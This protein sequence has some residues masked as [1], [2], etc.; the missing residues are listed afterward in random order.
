M[1]NRISIDLE[2][3]NVNNRRRGASAT[4]SFTVSFE[5]GDARAAQKVTSELVTLFLDENIKTR[6]ARAEDTSEFLKKESE[7]LGAQITIMGEQIAN[8]KQEYE[9]SLPENLGVNLQRIVS[10]KTALLETD[11][12]MS[13]L[14]ERRNL[15][16]IDLETLQLKAAASGGLTEEQQQQK[17]EL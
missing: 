1:R 3:A 10:L 2:S 5:Y 11:T 7:R 4:I 16:Q 12:E 8:Y 6:T 15:L 9:G 17:Q 14:N 13:E